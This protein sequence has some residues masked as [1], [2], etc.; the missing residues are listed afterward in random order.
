MLSPLPIRDIHCPGHFG[1]G[2]GQHDQ[3]KSGLF[4]QFGGPSRGGRPRDFE[5]EQEHGMADPGLSWAFV[6]IGAAAQ[7]GALLL[8]RRPMRLLRAGGDAQGTVEDNEESLVQSTRGPARTFYF[9]VVQF[10]TKRGE[11]I[12]FKS[13]TGGLTAR[14]KGSAV[15]VLYDPQRPQEGELATFQTLWLFPVVTAAFGLPFL[16]AGLFSLF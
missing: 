9:P 7:G 5:T 3:V 13:Q 10:T 8:L 14:P 16:A 11:R 12:S 6:A 1:D 15:R 4:P 2:G